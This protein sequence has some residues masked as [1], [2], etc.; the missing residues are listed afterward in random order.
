MQ[1]HSKCSICQETPPYKMA[2]IYWRW[3]W[4]S[5]D[6]RGFAQLFDAECFAGQK[7]LLVIAQSD[8][9]LCGLCEEPVE[10]PK[11]VD[12]W[13]TWFVP[14]KE[15]ASGAIRFHP[16]CFEKIVDQV[17]KNAKRLS[18]RPLA[19]GEGPLALSPMNRWDS[20]ESMGLAPA[21]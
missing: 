3:T 21:D 9:E 7:D 18:D 13:A 4:P 16:A 10:Y 19:Q 14:G 6:A 8:S 15:K 17:T 20:W 12:L 11:N 5:G 2:S 1:R